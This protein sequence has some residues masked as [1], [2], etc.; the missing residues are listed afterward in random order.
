MFLNFQDMF[1][2]ILKPSSLEMTKLTLQQ[3][4]TI[5]YQSNILIEQRN[6]RN[7]NRMWRL[8]NES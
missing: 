2:L 5:H 3:I 6:E 4:R 7:E 1:R 8:N